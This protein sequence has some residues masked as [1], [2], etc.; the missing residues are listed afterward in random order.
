MVS[1]YKNRIWRL[2]PRRNDAVNDTWMCDAGRLN[3]KSVMDPERL[4][5][6]LAMQDGTLKQTDWAAALD[7]AAS[8]ILEFKQRNGGKAFGVIVSPHLTNE[9][10]YRFGELIGAIGAGRVAMAMRHGKSDDFLIKPEKAANAR[11]VRELGLVRGEDDGLGELLRACSAGEIKGLYICGA[12]MVEVAGSDQLTPILE[13]LE[14]L[15]VQD[16]KLSPEFK[17]P[18]IVL[19]S[20]TFAEKNGTFTN[21][22]G[23][24]Q[25]IQQAIATPPGWLNDG[26]LFTGLL[27][28]LDSRQE[29]FEIA[30]IWES[31]ARDGTAFS[32]LRLEEIG[33]N[34][35]LL[36]ADT[37]IVRS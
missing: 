34:G 15:I 12:D 28:R 20:S 16:L 36:T 9:E 17:D 6:P 35:A 5:L 23:R 32:R 8:A 29:R 31:M 24:V 22:A 14:L 37:N 27:N 11:G 30:P 1:T 26:E 25:R 3:Y 4:R 21:H 19:P 10:N 7:R 18:A 13:K 33:T 2:L